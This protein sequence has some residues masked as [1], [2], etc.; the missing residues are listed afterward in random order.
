M[1]TCISLPV[2]LAV[3]LTS[4]LAAS[5]TPQQSLRSSW[6]AQTCL[7]IPAALAR[8]CVFVRRPTS[9]WHSR[10]STMLKC[11]ASASS[12]NQMSSFDNSHSIWKSRFA[13][14]PKNPV[15]TVD[16]LWTSTFVSHVLEFLIK[17]RN[18]FALP[19]FTVQL[20]TALTNI[21]VEVHQN[22][23]LTDVTLSEWSSLRLP[24]EQSMLAVERAL[25]GK[26]HDTG[27]AVDL[28]IVNV[29]A[30]PQLSL[31][32][33]KATLDP[34]ARRTLTLLAE[35][36]PIVQSIHKKS[37][38]DNLIFV[39][40]LQLDSEIYTQISTLIATSLRQLR[41]KSTQS[42]DP[43]QRVHQ[44]AFTPYESEFSKKLRDN[45]LYNAEAMLQSALLIPAA[46]TNS[47][48]TIN[49]I[50]RGFMLLPAPQ[51]DPFS[52]AEIRRR[53]TDDTHYAMESLILIPSL[54]SLFVLSSTFVT[55]TTTLE[56]AWDLE[57]AIQEWVRKQVQEIMA[58]VCGRAPGPF[59]KQ[60]LLPNPPSPKE[61]EVL[62]E[63]EDDQILDLEFVAH[64]RSCRPE[65]KQPP[66][67]RLQDDYAFF[68]REFFGLYHNIRG[69]VQKGPV[70]DLSSDED[71]C[72]R[73]ESS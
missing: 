10:Q 66:L 11:H 6:N 62:E 37:L 5:L 49:N 24:T 36:E 44:L 46:N 57:R 48:K 72:G 41:L 52:L 39:V 65:S 32:T 3:A 42:N 51:P 7:P 18:T 34:S 35:L 56:M 70:L 16:P 4:T 64:Q 14:A 29:A 63:T 53:I 60:P 47:P 58:R 69:T 67:E 33:L 12:E 2:L 17:Q 45:D 38:K 23:H 30:F 15:L 9:L 73:M 71:V 43:T 55:L 27:L 40:A 28:D 26:N 22:L 8:S 1:L 20:K 19:Q 61:D 21:K 50:V 68:A 13:K 31:E 25:N 59:Y 54:A